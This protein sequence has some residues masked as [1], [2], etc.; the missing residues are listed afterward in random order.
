MA[1]IKADLTK[2]I[3]RLKRESLYLNIKKTK[4][5]TT[6]SFEIDGEE[7]ELVTSSTFLGSEVEKEGNCDREIK[8]RTSIGK[9][10]MIGLEKLWRD[11]QVS[12]NTKKG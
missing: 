10:T 8:R 6:A 2:L 11:K 3:R 9:A 12:I 5:T 7:I 1:G 4:I